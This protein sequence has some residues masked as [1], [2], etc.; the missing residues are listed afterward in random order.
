LIF[1]CLLFK[2]NYGISFFNVLWAVRGFILARFTFG[3]RNIMSGSEITIDM[4]EVKFDSSVFVR[5]KQLYANGRMQ[6]RVLVLISGMDENADGVSLYGHP[7]LGTLRLISYNGAQ[8]LNGNWSV[9]TREN[10][11]AHDM[12]G[13]E[14]RV[15]PLVPAAN[16]RLSDPADDVQVF[17]FW[18]SCSTP[19]SLQIAAEIT[20]DGKTIRTNGQAGRDKSVTLEAISPKHYALDCFL[21]KEE[22]V[23]ERDTFQGYVMQYSLGLYAERRMISLLD[24]FSGNITANED[25]AVEFFSS[26]NLSEIADQRKTFIGYMAPVYGMYAMLNGPKGYTSVSI[27][28]NPG[29]L[30][31]FNCVSSDY[32]MGRPEK[33]EVFQLSV[34]DEFGT[35]HR[36]LV[37]A[38]MIERTFALDQF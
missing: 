11:F 29:K 16:N 8:P 24:W 25:D 10:R 32:Q 27:N 17:E 35:E 38:N 33:R 34:V 7:D 36:L 28:Q 14:A 37:K 21:L 1:G 20:L 3:E 18:V 12:T 19:G 2:G 4:F 26:G 22:R 15:T 6:I 13:G 9:S 5:H 30:S 23:E 31:L